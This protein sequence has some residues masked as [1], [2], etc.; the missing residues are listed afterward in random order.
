[1][2]SIID[3]ALA[4]PVLVQEK[5]QTSVDG[6]QM[7]RDVTTM[8]G[9]RMDDDFNEFYR[10]VD[11]Y[12][13]TWKEPDQVE[14]SDAHGSSNTAPPGTDHGS[15]NVAQAPATNP[16]L[17]TANPNPLVEPSS[18]PGPESQA[19]SDSE[20]YEWLFEPESDDVIGT[21]TSSGHGLDHELSSVPPG[22]DHGLTNVV[23]APAPDPAS[24]KASPIPLIELS[25]SE[26]SPKSSPALSDSGY[27]W[28]LEPEGDDT[29]RTATSSG[30]GLDHVLSSVPTG[31]NHGS[32]NVVKAPAPN[33]A[34]STTNPIPL[35]ELSNSESSP[36]ASPALSSSKN[37]WLFE[38]QVDQ[39]IDF[40]KPPKIENQKKRPWIDLYPDPTRDP[41]FVSA[42]W[43]AY[44]NRPRPGSASLKEI[45]QTSGYQVGHVQHWQPD[46][47]LSRDSGFHLNSPHVPAS[48]VHPLST[49]ARLATWPEHEMV[50]PSGSSAMT[51]NPTQP[52]DPQAAT[53]AVQGKTKESRH[54]SGTTRDVGNA[55][56][57]ELQPDERSLDPRG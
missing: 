33:P 48:V 14:S 23:Q 45:G 31:P 11:D 34:S 2:L 18:S 15:T 24:S 57:R 28:L 21:A 20:D 47:G 51:P 40:S 42:F 55:A 8:L 50:T 7:P 4:A 53:Y 9:K 41:G 12:F 22:P 54:I 35:I 56:Q 6:V 30:Y 1:M 36:V 17:P 16:A 44:M 25:S 46:S 27:K 49:S 5:R 3:F 19:L 26:S 38:P 43:K 52:V 37:K 29:I 13:K 10:L 32:T 39:M